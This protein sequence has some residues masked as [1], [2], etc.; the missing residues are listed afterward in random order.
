MFKAIGLPVLQ[1]CL[2]W[3][4]LGLAPQAKAEDLL[5]TFRPGDSLWKVCEQYARDPH[6][7]WQELAQRNGI[8]SP[9]AIPAG[10][11]LRIPSEWLKQQPQP[12]RVTRARGE[13]LVYRKA[14]GEPEFAGEDTLIEL[15]DALET[16]HDGFARVTFA[17]DS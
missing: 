7:C 2:L 4:W 16:G 6:A 10:A 12:A 1:V 17:D 14:G 3:A 15:G 5:Y 13:L 9:R 11:R 8:A